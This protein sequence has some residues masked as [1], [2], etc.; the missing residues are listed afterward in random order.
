[1][2]SPSVQPTGPDFDPQAVLARLDGVGT[3]GLVHVER[4]P[5]RDAVRRDWPDWVDPQVEA[6]IRGSGI[7]SL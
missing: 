3:G 2:S 6:A 5:G 7:T 1:M 4:I